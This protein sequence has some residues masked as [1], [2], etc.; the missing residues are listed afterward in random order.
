LKKTPVILIIDSE[1]VFLEIS[2]KA[3]NSSYE[4]I[5]A[6]DSE[7]ALA[8]A[9]KRI[10]EVIVLGFLEPRGSSRKVACALD[11]NP[12]TSHIPVLV[13]DVSPEAYSRKGWRWS[14][15]FSHNIKG[16]VW[17]PIDTVELSK[18]VEGVLQRVKASTMNLSEVAQQTEEMLKRIDQ[19]KK[20]LMPET[21]N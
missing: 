6:S 4:V 7:D 12:A 13:V 11:E 5:C 17:R 15:G 19:L 2:K 20:L 10:P 14:D 18:T 9:A 3:F 8:K 1:A 16:Y 21:G